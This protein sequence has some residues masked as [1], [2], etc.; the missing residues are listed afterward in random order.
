MCRLSTQTATQWASSLSDSAMVIDL[1]ANHL[2]IPNSIL[3]VS[4]VA[5]EP[6]QLLESDA[7]KSIGMWRF[8]SL[9]TLRLSWIS[10]LRCICITL[11]PFRWNRYSTSQKAHAE[12]PLDLKF[13]YQ[14][15]ANII[16]HYQI[17]QIFV[18]LP[19]LYRRGVDENLP[20]PPKANIDLA[21]RFWKYTSLA[22]CGRWHGGAGTMVK[23][24][25]RALYCTTRM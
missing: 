6:R 18:N 12:A 14:I 16:G 1:H 3:E 10:W 11:L 19:L 13:Q 25:C 20:R 8:Q 7:H 4:I 24:R 5:L 22:C 23:W 15:I 17:P 2:R 9:S 21:S